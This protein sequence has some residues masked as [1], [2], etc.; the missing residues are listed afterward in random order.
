MRKFV[1]KSGRTKSA[2]GRNLPLITLQQKTGHPS[3]AAQPLA[4]QSIPECASSS[5]PHFNPPTPRGVGRVIDDR[6]IPFDRLFQSTHPARGGTY[7][8]ISALLMIAISIHPP[9]EGWDG[10][11][12]HLFG[13]TLDFNPPTPRGVG[14]IPLTKAGIEHNF[15]PPTPRG[16]GHN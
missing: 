7:C 2:Q 3:R 6:G 14:L 10:R 8:S 5:A 4:K 15:N 16:V 1:Y 13:A 12:A 9:R 11:R